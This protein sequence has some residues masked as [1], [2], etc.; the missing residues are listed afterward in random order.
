MQ[1]LNVYYKKTCRSGWQTSI[2]YSRE[3]QQNIS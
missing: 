3:H 1:K 2:I